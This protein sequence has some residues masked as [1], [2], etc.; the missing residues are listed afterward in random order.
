[1]IDPG[2]IRVIAFDLDGTLTQHRTPLPAESRALLDRLGA[3][4]KLLMVGAGQCRRIYKQMEGYPIDIIGNYGMQYCEYDA[5]A[6]ALRT[7]RDEH[8]PCDRAA[9]E[10]R[11]DALRREHGY[12]VFT[13]DG[14]EYHDSGCVT[15]PLLGTKADIRDKLAFDPDRKKR[16][17]F[18][19]E[20]CA[21]FP[22]YTVFIGGSS[23]FDLAPLPYDKNYA[24]SNYCR[25]KGLR[26]EELLY[27]GDDYGPGGNDEAVYRADFPFL[28]VDDYRR[29][30]EV[31]A[32]LLN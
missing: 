3:R 18:Y 24:L 10:A 8:A 30:G 15:F 7:V 22:E 6:G 31:L 32:P 14:V 20:V 4:Y 13:G 12:T 21:L 26:H 23:S 25:E 17:A 28:C 16:A 27:V 1:M 2:A 19:A 5:A 9:V 11:I 29:V